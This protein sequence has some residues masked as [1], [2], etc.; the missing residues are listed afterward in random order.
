MEEAERQKGSFPVSRISVSDPLLSCGWMT[1][2][3]LRLLHLAGTHPA[4][5][6]RLSTS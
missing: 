5:M 2:R 6:L 3:W 1:G 4:D